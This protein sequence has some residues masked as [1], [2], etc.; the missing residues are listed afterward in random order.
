MLHLQNKD[1]MKAKDLEKV[2]NTLLAVAQ[3]LN[4]I[5]AQMQSIMIQV[6][7]VKRSI[8]DIKMGDVPTS[9]LN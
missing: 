7:E 3:K 2:E 5:N 9:T 4:E 6:Y 1:L 8:N